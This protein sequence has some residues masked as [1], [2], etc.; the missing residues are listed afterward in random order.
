MNDDDTT[1][2]ARAAAN[3]GHGLTAAVFNALSNVDR[4]KWQ[5]LELAGAEAAITLRWTDGRV[6]VRL[7]F[8][9]GDSPPLTVFA[10]NFES[11]SI[12][13]MH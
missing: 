8:V 12:G 10:L 3:A 2:A 13:G 4:E 7:G 6:E 11:A 5:Q 9:L 1:G